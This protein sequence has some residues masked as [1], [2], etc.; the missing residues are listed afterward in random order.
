MHIICSSID[1]FAQFN[2]VSSANILHIPPQPHPPKLAPLLPHMLCVCVCAPPKTFQSKTTRTVCLPASHMHAC[3]NT[4][5]HTDTHISLYGGCERRRE[6]RDRDRNAKFKWR[7]IFNTKAIHY[8]AALISLMRCLW[9]E[10]FRGCMHIR[11]DD[12]DDYGDDYGAIWLLIIANTS[13]ILST[14]ITDFA[15]LGVPPQV[16]RPYRPETTRRWR[17]PELR[18]ICP[19]SSAP[20]RPPLPHAGCTAIGS[21]RPAISTASMCWPTVLL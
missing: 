9:F 20:I 1:K 2:S 12:D 14:D 21:I 3:T 17:T 7:A 18:C 13:S 4:H 6:R 8:S 19:S 10:A 5:T 16:R 15:L 11:N